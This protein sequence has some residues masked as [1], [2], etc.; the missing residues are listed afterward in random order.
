MSSINDTPRLYGQ[1]P[2]EQTFLDAFNAG[3]LPHAWLLA[4]PEGTGKATFAHLA[5][6]AILSGEAALRHDPTVPAHQR[7]AEG[8]ETAL[9]LLTRSINEKTGKLRSNIP[10][11][12]IRALKRALNL[13]A[14]EG[15][16][17]VVI[18]DPAEDMN[19]SAANALLKVLEEPPARVVFFLVTH[20]PRRLLPT[21]LSRCRRLDFNPLSEGDL[22]AAFE[23]ATGEPPRDSLIAAARGSVGAALALAA[24]D[25]NALQDAIQSVLAPLPAQIDRVALHALA[26]TAAASGKDDA[27][28]TTTKL[29]ADL[30]AR[31]ATCAVGADAPPPGYERLAPIAPPQ[32]APHWA[33]ATT[34]ITALTERTLA[35]NLDRRQALLDMVATIEKVAKGA[36]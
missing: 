6:R 35:L 20:A 19:P 29:I 5:A 21:I 8:N 2:A 22:A 34:Q 17:R 9:T 31:M 14:T 18:V 16:W 36:A 30:S 4:G 27:F 10:V 33:E 25:G 1:A 26:D 32:S 11:D 28:R 24:Q 7:I 13:A 15:G 12:D 23:D 3:R